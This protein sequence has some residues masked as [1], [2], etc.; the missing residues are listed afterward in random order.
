MD[1]YSTIEWTIIDN[2]NPI[3]TIR[4]LGEPN[5]G[6]FQDRKGEMRLGMYRCFNTGRKVL[7][8]ADVQ[9]CVRS[10]LRIRVAAL[11]V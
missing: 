5:N 9:W 7:S 4:N 11:L 6:G 8:G 1:G 10:I 2:Q 3:A